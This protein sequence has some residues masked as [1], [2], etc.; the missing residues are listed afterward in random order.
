MFIYRNDQNFTHIQVCERLLNSANIHLVRNKFEQEI[1]M[2]ASHSAVEEK[3]VANSFFNFTLI[4]Y[5]F[6]FKTN[7]VVLILKAKFA[8]LG[9]VL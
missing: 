5:K 3:Q 1:Q 9:T 2:L 8:S 6:I 4:F 7:I